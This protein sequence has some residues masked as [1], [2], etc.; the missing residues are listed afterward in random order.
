MASRSAIKAQKQASKDQRERDAQ[1]DRRSVH[2]TLR[3]IAAELRIVKSHLLEPF[4]QSFK[5]REDFQELFRREPTPLRMTPGDPNRFTVF[6]SNSGMLGK[7]EDD[8]L[9]E[10]IVSVYS[11][12]KGLVD[13][14]NTAAQDF[15][16]WRHLPDGDEEKKLLKGSLDTLEKRMK[17]GVSEVQH[18]LDLLLNEI[19][20]YLKQP[21]I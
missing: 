11:N 17:S 13:Y 18:D 21:N 19:D 5:D 12:A 2:G 6:E 9:I 15:A 8:Q 4:Q 1:V 7:I 20:Q 16:L 3:A 10:H 14:T